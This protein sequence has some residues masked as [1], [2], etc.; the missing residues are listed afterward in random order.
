MLRLPV[1]YARCSLG[2]RASPIA[3]MCMQAQALLKILQP[4][5]IPDKHN[6]SG[7]IHWGKC[8]EKYLAC[9]SKGIFTREISLLNKCWA[10]ARASNPSDTLLFSKQ[11]LAIEHFKI[12]IQ[13]REKIWEDII[14]ML[15]HK[16]NGIIH[17]IACS[18]F[19]WC[20][21]QKQIMNIWLGI[22][23]L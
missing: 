5:T 18:Y 7:K 17:F 12:V 10:R 21:G 4:R 6:Y 20:H 22:C 23:M 14:R 3:P 8:L 9:D 2:C 1:A 16:R 19:S 15:L 11:V 13:T